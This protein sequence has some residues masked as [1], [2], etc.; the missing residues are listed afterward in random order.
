MGQTSR[1]LHDKLT[2]MAAPLDLPTG[3]MKGRADMP[4]MEK[5]ERG[6]SDA[7]LYRSNQGYEAD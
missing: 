4:N 7:D 1:K 3:T 2:K 5:H 6:S